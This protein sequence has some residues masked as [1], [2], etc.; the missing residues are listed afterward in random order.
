MNHPLSIPVSR[1]ATLSAAVALSGAAWVAAGHPGSGAYEVSLYRAYPAAF[2]VCIFSTILLGQLAA[3][4]EIFYVRKSYGWLYPLCLVLFANL[5]VLS[6]PTLRHY[7]FVTQWDDVNHFAQSL[8]ILDSRR[9]DPA[10]FYP[11]AHLLVAAFSRLAGLD[12]HAA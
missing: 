7:A 4:L 1:F 3:W 12:L 10:D 2:W 5:L 8:T 11:A 6:L 9:P